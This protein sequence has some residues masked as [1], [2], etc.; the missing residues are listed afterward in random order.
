MSGPEIEVRWENGYGRGPRD[1][2][3]DPSLSERARL[4]FV[5]LEDYAS[6]G[7]QIFPSR[8]TLA[9]HL[10]V[11]IASVKRAVA[12]LSGSGWMD[13]THRQ[14]TSNLYV[15]H[16]PSRVIHDPSTGSE[17]RGRVTHD[18]TTR[19]THDPR[20]GSPMTRE[21]EP[22]EAEPVEAEPSSLPVAVV[23]SDAETIFQHWRSKMSPKSKF[24]PERKRVINARL[25]DGYQPHELIEAIDGCAL[26]P[27][28]MGENPRHTRY[29]KLTLIMRNAEMVDQFRR[30]YQT[31]PKPKSNMEAARQLGDMFKQM[32]A[33]QN[34]PAPVHA[35]RGLDQNP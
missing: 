7:R 25:K 23:L 24:T 4:L 9:D 29:D 21:A 35:G 13:V 14:G 22:V 32:D 17:F 16:G 1:L 19:V 18:P 12:E 3:R 8:Q 5:L 15:L 27:F 33:N 11:S 10:G 31:P 2:I 20:V 28:H 30:F 26:S 34:D 6:P